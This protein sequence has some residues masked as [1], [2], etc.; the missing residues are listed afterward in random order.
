MAKQEKEQ[1][2]TTHRLV[3]EIRQLAR[4]FREVSGAFA[5][6]SVPS[7]IL[8][9]AAQKLEESRAALRAKFEPKAVTILPPKK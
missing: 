9:A 3:R 6:G 5:E 7:D 1:K 2:E 4:D 8:Y